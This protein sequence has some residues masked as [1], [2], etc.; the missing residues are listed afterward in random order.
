MFKKIILTL[1]ALLF[2]S[3][4]AYGDV[5]VKDLGDGQ[6]EITFLYQD[7]EAEEMNVIGSFN[8]WI[9]PGDAMVKNAAGM[10]E[11]KLVTFADD[12]IIYKFFDGTYISDANAPDE[13][14]D[15]FAGMNGLI[16]VADLLLEAPVAPVADGEAPKAPVKKARKKSTFGT[17]TYIESDTK[18]ST[19]DDEFEAVDST[20]NAK[21]VWTFDGDLTKNMPGHLELT[22]FDG[23]PTV[24]SDGDEGIEL[25]DGMETLAS[26]FIFN[27][28][29]YFGG[30]EKPVLDKFSFGFD[31]K[32]IS[33][34]TGYGN[35]TIPGHDSVL[36]E[37][38]DDGDIAAGDGYNS[39]N[40]VIDLEGIGLNI[41]TTIVPNKST[42]GDNYGMFAIVNS[43]MGPARVDFQ[44]EM[45]SS[46]TEDLA[47]FFKDMARQDM[48]L[49]LS[50]DLAP[51]TISAQTLVSSFTVGSSLMTR[52][53]EDR[54]AN[55][56][57]IAYTNEEA[58]GLSLAYKIRGYAAQMLYADNDDVLGIADTQ[59]IE[60]N[61]FLQLNSEIT[62]RLDVT[63]VLADE[64]ALDSNISL[65]FKPGA[66][67]DFSEKLGKT[68]TGDIYVNVGM[69][70]EPEDDEEPTIEVGATA[71]V[72]NI[73]LNYGYDGSDETVTFNS[74]LLKAALQNDITA[75]LGIGYRD[76]DDVT[77][78]FG[79][80]IGASWMIPAPKAKTPLLYCNFVYNIDPYETGTTEAKADDYQLDNISEGEAAIRLGIVWNY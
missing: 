32:Y 79:F 15:G 40:S 22:F 12:E 47:L 61:T 27:P 66:K 20:I 13:K 1:M 72:D 50:Y 76:G 24:W 10:W 36:W 51:L 62:P 14:D 48:V 37:T 19:L 43:T 70:T 71:T 44:Y 17:V 80:S 3:S 34:E 68:T 16:L 31:T 52:P 74:L 53:A 6:A 69:N 38:V 77:N 45:K 8:S 56:F 73:T 42:E 55:A 57:K 59:T 63:A 9:E 25:A 26:G 49:G 7:D 28:V 33:Y 75:E 64:E 5:S 60:L 29:Y 54:M 18:F 58:L 2:L 41:D 46:A 67:F 4:L 23:N 35:S 39:F 78:A 65:T 11:F 21:S 30:N